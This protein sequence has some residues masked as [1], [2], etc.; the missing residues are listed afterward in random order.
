MRAVAEERI[1]ILARNYGNKW[2]EV[3]IVC[4][5]SNHKFSILKLSIGFCGVKTKKGGVR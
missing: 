2:G 3:D 1:E 5:F 4:K